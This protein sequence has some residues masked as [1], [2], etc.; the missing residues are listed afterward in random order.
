MRLCVLNTEES[1]LPGAGSP[2]E[3]PDRN[4][5]PPAQCPADPGDVLRAQ[6]RRVPQGAER[7]GAGREESPLPMRT[8]SRAEP[9]AAAPGRM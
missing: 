9:G 4:P 8:S 1:F 2:Q 7:G 3:R 6:G 5:V